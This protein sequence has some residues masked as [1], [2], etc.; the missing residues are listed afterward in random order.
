MRNDLLPIRPSGGATFGHR[1]KELAKRGTHRV[2]R[3]VGAGRNETDHGA[4]HRQA[5][6]GSRDP[7]PAHVS[8]APEPMDGR[9]GNLDRPW[10]NP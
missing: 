8:L 9:V 1:P 7:R 2:K 6:S 10:R 4:G 5:T 3:M